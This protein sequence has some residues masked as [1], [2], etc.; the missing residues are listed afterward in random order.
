MYIGCFNEPPGRC[1]SD[2][3][4]AL[5]FLSQDGAMTVEKCIGLAITR[6]FK[7]VGLQAYSFCFGGNDISEYKDVSTGCNLPCSGNNSQICGGGC[8]NSIYAVPGEAAAASLART[9]HG[10]SARGCHPCTLPA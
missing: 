6:G 3:D 9:I 7:Y 1:D 5:A 2:Q 8:I 10:L 4:R